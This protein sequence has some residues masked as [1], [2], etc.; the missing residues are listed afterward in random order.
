MLTH[1]L[2]ERF[3]TEL[4][5]AEQAFFLRK[6]LEAMDQRGYEPSEDLFHYCF[7]LTLKERLR[8]LQSGA[9]AGA[10]GGYLRLLFVEGMRETEEAVGLYEERL[11][12][13]QGPVPREAGKRFIAYLTE[14]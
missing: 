1:R 8:L 5:P 9:G 12:R 4:T 6:A 14:T 10:G 13:E 7:F 2:K 11:A 3:L